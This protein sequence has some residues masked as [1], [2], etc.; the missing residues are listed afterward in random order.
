[1]NWQQLQTILWLRWR[2]LC[3][4]SRRSHGVGAVFSFVVTAMALGLGALS[5]VGGLAGGWFGSVDKSPKEIMLVWLVITLLFL[6][7]WMIGLMTELQRSETIDLQ[8]L[9]HLPVAL[10]Q[11]FAINYLA[12]HFSLSLVLVVPM[13]VGLGLGLALR[14][15]PE[16]ILLIPLALSMVVMVTAWTYCL[17][18][19][20][21]TMMSNPRRRRTVI[22]CI[23]LAFVVL[24]QGPNLYFN[25]LQRK[26]F[27]GHAQ[28]PAQRQE[29]NL[30]AY[31]SFE[32]LL[33]VQGFL[34]PLWVPVGA[35]ALVA[36]N[37]VPALL[38]TLGCAG[39][40]ALGLLRAYR[41]TLAFYQGGASHTTAAK[42]YV[43]T[44]AARATASRRNKNAT[45]FLEYSI[46][47]VSEQSAALALATLRS[48]LRAPEVKMAWA[49]SFIVT[50]IFGGIFLF[51]STGSVPDVAKPFIATAAVVF[52]L[53]FLAHFF[54][55]QFGFDRDGF[56]A[57]ILSPADRRLILL[58]K[59]LAAAPVG[60][61]FGLLLILMTACRL[62]LPPF[63]VLATLFQ[64]TSVLLIA[65]VAGNLLSILLPYRIQPGSMKPTKMPGLAMVMLMFFQVLFPTAMLPVFA[66]PLLE[67]LWH[68]LG[69]PDLVPVN[70][71]VSALLLGLTATIYW[72]T[73]GPLGRLLQRRETK[74]LAV[75]TVE[76]E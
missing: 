75:I 28:T 24:A 49:S 68:R 4:Q 58:G 20:L 25:V 14:R 6:L 67:L 15:G 29:Q 16:M 21:A 51:R 72:Q 54:A 46:P 9:M 5:F 60:A 26:N 7:V 66:G 64:L 38:G 55:N 32:N 69:W 44:E 71:L 43:S 27:S 40:A 57:L 63:T 3:N 35:Q 33:A 76:V 56:R 39:L 37:P 62:H 11:M 48:L 10:G 73:L 61:A 52:P 13:M 22:M 42:K 8:K 65:G 17:R 1:M 36:G 47:L 19:W 70:A 23:T 2:L 31:Q 41:N 30:Q 34:P 74:I 18:G 53:F 12:S 59:N 45:G 50:L